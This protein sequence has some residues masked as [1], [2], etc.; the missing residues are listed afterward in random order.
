MCVLC[1]VSWGLCCS[2]HG[3]SFKSTSKTWKKSCYL[4]PFPPKIAFYLRRTPL[5]CCQHIFFHLKSWLF[6]PVSGPF[7]G[8]IWMVLSREF[9]NDV[10]LKQFDLFQSS[11][12]FC[13]FFC[14]FKKQKNTSYLSHHKLWCLLQIMASHVTTLGLH[15]TRQNHHVPPPPNWRRF[16][17]LPIDLDHTTLANIAELHLHLQLH[18][19][20]DVF[21]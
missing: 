21:V 7:Q 16:I 11:H 20:H 5:R 15:M 2:P 1:R 18:L 3:S 10:F 13:R 17:N 9:L 14:L 12:M 4:T 8:K 19:S 6:S